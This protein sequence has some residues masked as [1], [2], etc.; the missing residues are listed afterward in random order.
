MKFTNTKAHV[1]RANL[2]FSIKVGAAY[3]LD[4]DTF[5]SLKKTTPFPV[6]NVN[7]PN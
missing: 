6:M 4:T 2:W 7:S 3:F 1:K 5:I